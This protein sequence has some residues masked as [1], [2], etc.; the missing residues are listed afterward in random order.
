M[1]KLIDRKIRRISYGYYS[2][3]LLTVIAFAIAF[4]QRYTDAYVIGFI[5][6]I[7]SGFAKIML[8]MIELQQG[9]Y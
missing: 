4:T 7:I 3:V 5:F 6:L 1:G 2:Y 8:L 9:N